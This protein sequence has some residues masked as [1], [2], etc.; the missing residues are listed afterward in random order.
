MLKT[1]MARNESTFKTGFPSKA[2]PPASRRKSDDPGCRGASMV[3]DGV[4]ALGRQPFV[5]S[6]TILSVRKKAS[7]SFRNTILEVHNQETC[8]IGIPSWKAHR[9]STYRKRIESAAS[10]THLL[11]EKRSKRYGS[12]LVA[13]LMAV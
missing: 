1:K 9:M 11:G 4:Q 5:S 8:K 6:G 13:F 12:L 2:I 7:K 10:D 3:G